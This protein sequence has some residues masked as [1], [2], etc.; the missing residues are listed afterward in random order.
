M[1]SGAESG[2]VIAAAVLLPVGAAVGAALGAGWLAWKAGSLLVEANRAVDEEIREKKRQ[3]AEAMEHR[4]RSALA[5]HSQLVAMCTQLISELDGTRVSSDAADIE[6]QEKLKAEL[7][8]LCEKEVP[9]DVN[10][11]EDMNS[12]DLMR[13]DRLI[14]KKKHLLELQF[15]GGGSEYHGLSLA[16]L[17][18]DI[19]IAIAA[20]KIQATKGSDIRAA[21]PV[22]LERAKLNEKLSR[23]T[24]RVASALGHIYELSKSHYGLPKSA[25]TWFDSC[26][27]GIDSLI[28]LMYLPTTGNSE[29]KKGISR[30]EETME[31]YDT[32]ISDIDYFAAIYRVYA[33]ACEALAE[34][35][36]SIDSFK[37][38]R[39]VENS[40][41]E[42]ERRYERAKECREIREKLGSTAYICYAWD[43]ELQA[44]GYKV[45]KRSEIAEMAKYKPQHA[46]LGESKLPFYDWDEDDLTQ[47]YSMTDECSLQ[48]IVHDDGSVSMQ[49]ISD[50]DED[51]TKMI[52]EHHCSLLKL[53]HENLRKNWFI[54]YDYEETASPEEIT[55][56]AEWFGTEEKAST[57]EERE[58]IAVRGSRTR[59]RQRTREQ[60]QTK[61]QTL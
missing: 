38:A 48:V 17:M 45:H 13:L 33:D 61:K 59:R 32:L 44:L 25:K 4:K 23:V 55:T 39:D 12:F 37:S 29:I 18:N 35:A 15:E 16:D 34:K 27:N 50:G 14:S 58:K 43:Q 3:L 20:M 56:K 22:A 6:E 30:V 8:A 9:D 31:Q 1:S 21:D 40:L 57:V 2:G 49:T 36:E 26:F 11:I 54:M 52:Q 47:L 41:H 42:L 7:R 53:L 28:G 60:A 10:K 46:H 51:G 19:R 5:A 24:A